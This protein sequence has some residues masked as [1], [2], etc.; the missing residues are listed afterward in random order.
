MRLK[1][2]ERLLK[3]LKGEIPAYMRREH[4]SKDAAYQELK[5]MTGQD[6]GLDV[7]RWEAWIKEQEA[8]GVVFRVPRA[9]AK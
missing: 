8:A 7:R 4:M 1:P 9:R 3:N 5:A 6:F 2:I